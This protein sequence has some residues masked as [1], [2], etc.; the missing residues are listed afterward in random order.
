M[1]CSLWD[2]INQEHSSLPHSL[3]NEGESSLDYMTPRTV[4]IDMD[5]DVIKDIRYNYPR[6]KID[7]DQMVVGKEDSG[8]NNFR[9][10]FTLGKDI[11]D[12]A[13]DVIRK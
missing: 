6:L 13:L 8:S 2:Q 4:L 11:L 3:I 1:C 5:P 7:Q 12:L 9:A 10:Q